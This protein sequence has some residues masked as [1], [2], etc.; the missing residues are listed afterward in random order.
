MDKQKIL[1]AVKEVP[2]TLYNHKKKVI[3]VLIGAYFL[4][5]AYGF[6]RFVKPLLDLKK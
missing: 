2:S 6:Y 1:K 5:K 4:R 3:L